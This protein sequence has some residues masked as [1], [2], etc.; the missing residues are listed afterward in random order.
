MYRYRHRRLNV[1]RKSYYDFPQGYYNT[2]EI[3]GAYTNRLQRN[4]RDAEWGEVQFHPMLYNMVWAG[5]EADLLPKLKP[6]TKVNGKLNSIDKLFDQAA[7]VES[8]LTQ[9][10]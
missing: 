10:D 5:L 1:A 6:C 9:Y 3:I 4:W 8:D 7:D 2:D